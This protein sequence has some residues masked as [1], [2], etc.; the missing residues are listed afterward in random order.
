[1]GTSAYALPRLFVAA[2]IMALCGCGT[3]EFRSSMTPIDVIDNNFVE[4][5]DTEVVS[6]E[7]LWQPGV[8]G[9]WQSAG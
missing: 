2:L 8:S 9:G 4:S 7:E 5:V 6:T 3:V 1:M